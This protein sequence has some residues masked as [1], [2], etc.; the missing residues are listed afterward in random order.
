MAYPTTID[1]F[2]TKLD[3]A[4][5][6]IYAAHI[7]A[8]QTVALALEVKVGIDSSADTSSI[9][10]KINRFSPEYG[11]IWVPAAAMV[12]C[13]TNGAVAGSLEYDTDK[14][15]L[16]YYAFADG[17]TDQR[18]Q[19]TLIMPENWDRSTVK[20]KF[21]WSCVTVGAGAA[22]DTATFAIK[23][24]ALAD[25][26][27]ITTAFGTAVSV[28]DILLAD[29]GG[30]MQISAASGALTIA[31][32]PALNEIITFE[33]YRD[34]S[35]DDCPVDVWLFGCLIQYKMINTVAAW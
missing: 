31:G 9:D 25:S 3:G 19:F 34:V 20:V 21:Y 18:V 35:E 24:G 7:N 32:S 33:I 28:T 26:E 14:R 17:A 10:Y 30:D 29:D 13:T 23:A 15:I 8:I 16:D 12:P 1:S 11:T 6:T 4:G 27:A 22:D 2:T 5:N